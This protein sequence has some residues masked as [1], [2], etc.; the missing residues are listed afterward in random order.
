MA[1]CLADSV[2]ASQGLDPGDLVTRFRAWR[3]KGENSVTGR[4]FDI[5]ITTSQTIARF[6]ADGNPLAASFSPEAAGN[7]S[8]VRLAPVP[9]LFHTNEAAARENAVLQSRTT[10]GAP[11]M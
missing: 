9:I 1:L 4:C 2:L 7:G 8:I 10:H 5:G 3:D 11:A 6:V